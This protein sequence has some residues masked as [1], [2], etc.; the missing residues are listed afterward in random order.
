[1]QCPF[2]QS[3]IWFTVVLVSFALQSSVMLANLMID[4][5]E[6]TVKHPIGVGGQGT[7]YKGSWKVRASQVLAG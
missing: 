1:M 7:V 5:G 2:L 6:L 3:S 4:W